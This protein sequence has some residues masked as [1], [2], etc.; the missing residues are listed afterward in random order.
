MGGCEHSS[1]IMR[2][3]KEERRI[4]GCWGHRSDHDK[5]RAAYVAV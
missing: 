4:W 1:K 5:A 3:K 2:K